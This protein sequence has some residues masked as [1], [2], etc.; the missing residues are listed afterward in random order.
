[1]K[2]VVIYDS[3]HGNTR[4]VAEAI[5]RAAGTRPV[6][7]GAADIRT[8]KGS[9]LLV[10]G[11]P[12]LGGRATTA[13]QAF[14]GGIPAETAARLAVATFDTRLRPRIFGI[15]GY[16]AG[17]MMKSLRLSGCT[18]RAAPEGFFVKGRAGPLADG[19]AE[20]AA[21]WGRQLVAAP[22][23]AASRRAGKRKKA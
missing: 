2:T 6:R 10:I 22:A 15:F 5:A 18:V 11:S 23:R 19:E 9:E 3:V 16:A 8:L 7:V 17:R 12:T 1:M 20:R 13:I 14:V 21:A 4:R